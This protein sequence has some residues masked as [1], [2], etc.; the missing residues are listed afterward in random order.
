[1]ASG[2]VVYRTR[3]HATLKRNFQVMPGTQWLELPCPNIPDRYEDLV[4]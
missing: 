2:T 1:M 4:R 3:M